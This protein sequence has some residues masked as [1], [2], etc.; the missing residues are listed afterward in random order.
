MGVCGV[1]AVTLRLTPPTH[2]VLYILPVPEGIAAPS[3]SRNTPTL[4]PTRPKVPLLRLTQ[5]SNN[6]TIS[7]D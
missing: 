5:I 4:E 7:S 6:Q 2:I 3:T 1:R